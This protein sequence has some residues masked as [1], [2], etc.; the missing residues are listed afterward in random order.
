MDSALRVE[1]RR[2]EDE[3]LREL[4]ARDPDRVQRDV[5]EVAGLRL[6]WTRQRLDGAA[7]DALFERAAACEV[8]EALRVLFAGERVNT[9]EGRAA[10]H[11]ALRLPRE[12]R[13]EVD[14]VD[15][16]PQ[17]HAQLDRVETFVRR[18]HDGAHRGYSGRPIQR[19]VNIGIGGSDLGPRMVCRALAPYARAT[20]E[21]VPL[22]VQFVS[23][24]D[25]AALSAVLREADPE[26][27][28]FIVASKTFGTQETLTNARA[29]RAWLL[30]HAPDDSAVARHFVAV[31]TA[32]DRV[33]A[34]G[35]DPDNM[36]GFWDWVGGRYS[37]WS[38]IGLPV[39]LLLGMD[40]FRAFL[41]GAHAMDEHVRQT[42]VSSNAAVRM[43]LVDLWNQN[44]L[45]SQSRAVLPYDERLSLLPPYLQQ[46]EMESLGKRVGLDGQVVRDD[47]G[48]VV[49]GAV[50]TD[51]QHAFFQLLHQGTRFIP[52][53]FIG[54]AR[55]EH[56]LPAQ[57]PLLI[58]NLVAQA[59][60]LAM[61]K[62][63]AAVRAEMAAA[64]QSPDA[65]DA[66]APHRTFPGNRPSTLILLER[67][68]PATLGALIAL[69]EHKIYVLATLWGINAFDQWGV[70]LGKQLA[71]QVLE[72]LAP[73]ATTG[74]HDLAT[75]ATL[76]WLRPRLTPRD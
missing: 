66:L 1:A 7:W 2:L 9:T 72:D 17:V 74:E 45:G 21:G 11:T 50:G 57:H 25:G 47:T 5:E 68:D 34:F 28:L 20:A 8:P 70:E 69:F 58:A 15:V 23:N 19:V 24:V 73:G 26:T 44:L 32:R 65:I 64:G 29:A 67:L 39:A 16:V 18:I 48:A 61:G 22:T 6:D 62:D 40:G 30:R 46:A 41:G 56:D 54:V 75:T 3:T 14:G 37:V 51:G 13:C 4:F 55:P 31:S 71:G 43:A 12:A 76:D 60:A 38:S 35:I 27:T 63:E 33:T 59:E 36:F 52:A 10:L 42:P 49:W 53:E